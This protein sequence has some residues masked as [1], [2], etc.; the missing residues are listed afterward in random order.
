MSFR[1]RLVSLLLLTNA[2]CVVL[3]PS[4]QGSA[5]P[6]GPN[7]TNA[8]PCQITMVSH[9]FGGFC[10]SIDLVNSGTSPMTGWEVEFELPPGAELANGW[11]GTYEVAGTHVTV[12]ADDPAGLLEPGETVE[13]GFCTDQPPQ[14]LQLVPGICPGRAVV[15]SPSEPSVAPSR[16]LSD[17]LASVDPNRWSIGNGYEAGDARAC[18]YSPARVEAGTD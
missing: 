16:G 10:G 6:I 14:D 5:I 11:N 8:G 15:T 9:Q 12:T 17:S 2:A 1:G 3:G 18:T 4:E 7:S 13:L